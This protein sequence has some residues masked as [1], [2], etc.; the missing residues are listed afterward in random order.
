MSVVRIHYFG[1]YALAE[2]IRMLLSHAKVPY[3]D[4]NYNY[5]TLPIVKASGILEFGQIP[6]LEVEGKF[7]AQSGAILKYLGR[8]Y[9]YYPE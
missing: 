8:K 1:G 4:V 2:A 3:E 5:E 6:V 9:D 7:Y